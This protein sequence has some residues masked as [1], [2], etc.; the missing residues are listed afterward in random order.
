MAA[1]REPIELDPDTTIAKRIENAVDS[2]GEGE[3][4]IGSHLYVVHRREETPPSGE[5]KGNVHLVLAAAKEFREA[6]GEDFDWDQVRKNIEE[7]RE[8]DRNNPRPIP[9][10]D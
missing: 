7:L 1:H 3:L 8:Y 4:R 6:M 9:K 2:S 5:R 10:F